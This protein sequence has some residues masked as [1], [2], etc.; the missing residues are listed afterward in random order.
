MKPELEELS[1]TG[2]VTP[3]LLADSSNLTLIQLQSEGRKGS[4]ATTSG[5]LVAGTFVLFGFF[6]AGVW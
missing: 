1:Q 6:Y 2:H 5:I 4:P 3:Q